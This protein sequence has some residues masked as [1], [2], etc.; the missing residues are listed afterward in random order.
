[1][2][3]PTIP[4]STHGSQRARHPTMSRSLRVAMITA[5]MPVMPQTPP[6]VHLETDPEGRAMGVPVTHDDFVAPLSTTV[7][8]LTVRTWQPG[9]GQ[10]LAEVTNASHEHLSRWLEWARTTTTPAA[11]E[12]L[13]REFAGKYLTRQDFGL[14]IWRDGE[15]VG[16]TGFHPRWG[17]LTHGIAEVGM[18]I[19]WPHANR[20]LGTRVLGMLTEWGLSDQWGWRQ[21]LWLCDHDNHASARVAAKAGYRREGEVR[22]TLGRGTARESTLVFSRLATDSGEPG[23]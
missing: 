22:G 1:M 9:D 2:D 15:L 4:T 6:R 12:V 11:A 23:D 14:G 20:G 17:P 3:R 8:D 18:W 19:A 5:D 10:V 21:L 13:V 7:G 16:G